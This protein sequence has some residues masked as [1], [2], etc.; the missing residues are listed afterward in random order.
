MEYP[1]TLR[2][3]AQSAR[4]GCGGTL[5]TE[6]KAVMRVFTDLGLVTHD[7]LPSLPAME[8]SGRRQASTIYYEFAAYDRFGELMTYQALLT[9]FVNSESAASLR[10]V[11]NE[12]YEDS[13][14]ELPAAFFFF[15]EDYE[16]HEKYLTAFSDGFAD[17]LG[18]LLYEVHGEDETDA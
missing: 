8:T 9:K 10:V 3:S 1:D 2:N 16:M 15:C 17:E 11:L 6:N 4:I 18:R 13:E 5:T 7:H 14:L 12:L